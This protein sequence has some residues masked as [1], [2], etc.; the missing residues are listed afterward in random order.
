MHPAMLPRPQAALLQPRRGKL[1]TTNET[2]TQKRKPGGLMFSWKSE[3]E[4]AS[5]YKSPV[6]ASI[7]QYDIPT[8]INRAYSSTLT[9]NR[10]NA[11]PRAHESKKATW[12]KKSIRRRTAHSKRSKER[13]SH[14]RKL[15]HYTNTS[16]PSPTHLP[17]AAL[18]LRPCIK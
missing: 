10:R 14:T 11:L 5:P 1:P 9:T 7:A 3:C 6:H 15:H 16:T 12:W 2:S 17:N 8:T 4:T 18:R 13:I